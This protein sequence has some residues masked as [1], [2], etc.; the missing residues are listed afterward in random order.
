M[1]KSDVIDQEKIPVDSRPILDAVSEK[2][3]F[4][5]N[6]FSGLALQPK[7]L[8]AFVVLDGSFSE[9]SLSSIERQVVLLA[10]SVENGSGYCVAGHTLFARALEVPEK[11]LAAMRSGTPVDDRKL[12]ALHTFT[13]RLIVTRGHV[14]ARDVND[15]VSAGYSREQILD[16]ILGLACKTVTNYVT[17]AM[18]IPLDDPFKAAEWPGLEEVA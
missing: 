3:G 11:Q 2:I 16:V 10:A 15:F 17:S 4:I 7:V 5:P 13:R 12:E 18:Q 6:L 9:T 14:T 1:S 8:E